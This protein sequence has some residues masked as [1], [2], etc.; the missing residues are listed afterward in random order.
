[1]GY[2]YRFTVDIVD[3]G[4]RFQIEINFTSAQK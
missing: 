1:M 4:V 2:P 3:F